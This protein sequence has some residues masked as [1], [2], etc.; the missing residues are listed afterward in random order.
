MHSTA[1]DGNVSPEGVVQRAKAA[2]L[3]GIALTDHDTLAGYR[4]VVAA[5]TPSGMTL[6]PGVEINALV[7]RDLGLWEGELPAMRRD[8]P[9][10]KRA[11]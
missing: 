10:K 9:P 8:R 11:S 7:T 1:S 2:G 4:E 3:S 5:G 6:I